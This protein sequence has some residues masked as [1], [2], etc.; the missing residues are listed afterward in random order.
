MCHILETAEEKYFLTDLGARAGG[1]SSKIQEIQRRKPREIEEVCKEDLENGYIDTV[2]VR[3]KLKNNFPLD[4]FDKKKEKAV[5]D[6]LTYKIKKSGINEIN[7]ITRETT[8]CTVES[9]IFLF[10]ITTIF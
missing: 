2:I 5:L 10:A 6:S 7:H 9:A 1:T 3:K 4:V 8:N